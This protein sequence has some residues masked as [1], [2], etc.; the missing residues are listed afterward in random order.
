[1]IFSMRVIFRI[2][3]KNKYLPALAFLLAKYVG[4]VEG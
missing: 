4:I 2:L 3:E 1:M